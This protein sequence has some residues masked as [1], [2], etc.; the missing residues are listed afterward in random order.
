MKILK[1]LNK[2]YFTILFCFLYFQNIDTFSNEPVDIWNLE[3]KE[4]IEAKP[5]EQVLQKEDIRE[6]IKN[7]NS[8]VQNLRLI[9]ISMNLCHLIKK[10]FLVQEL[11]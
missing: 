2:K 4:N 6:I 5:S 11:S 7:Y 8:V 1:L 10:L 9:M 3:N